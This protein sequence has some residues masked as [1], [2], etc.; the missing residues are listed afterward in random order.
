MN[1]WERAICSRVKEIREAIKWSQSD[2]SER[3]GITRDQLASIEAGRT[4]LRY[5]IA[6]RIGQAFGISLRWLEEGDGHIDYTEGDK[7]PLPE[8][9]GLSERSL[10]SEVAQHFSEFSDERLVPIGESIAKNNPAM[11]DESSPISQA[12]LL[13]LVTE[14]LAGKEGLTGTEDITNRLLLG[15][16][17]KMRA[18][19]WIASVPLGHVYEFVEQLSQD[20][21]R[22]MR[23]FPKENPRTI[24]S[25][26]EKL[27]WERVK[28]AN[29]KK[30]LLALKASIKP[31]THVIASDNNKDV[32]AQWPLLKARLQK[33]TSE[34]GSKSRLAEFLGLPLSSVSLWLSDSKSARE[35]GAET[36]LRMLYWVERREHK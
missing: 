22:F 20:A 33:A 4:P 11:A 2:F 29:A 18:D 28:E 3:V 21:L 7:L 19:E 9:T 8:G 13:K 17:L 12:D 30:Y 32:K 6:W 27:T 15:S 23:S 31:L 26:W 35:P 36:A 24:D 10:L 5:D 34:K 16:Y 14:T 1:D 25:R